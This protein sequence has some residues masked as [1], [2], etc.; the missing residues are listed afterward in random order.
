MKVPDKTRT[1]C[2]NCGKHTV[3]NVRLNRKGKEAPMNRGR[4]KYKVIKAGYGGSPRTPKKDVYKIGK[5]TVLL[6]ECSQCKKKQQ[7]LFSART[8]KVVEV[9]GQ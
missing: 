7:R 4:R 1:N 8:K 2:P 3:H 9:G 6:L 5:R